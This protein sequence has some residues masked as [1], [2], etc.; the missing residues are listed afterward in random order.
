MGQSMRLIL[1]EA[2]Y[3]A[4][5]FAYINRASNRAA[6]VGCHEPPRGVRMPRSFSRAVTVRTL[7][8][9][10]ERRSSTMARR[11]AARCAAFAFTAATAC[12]LPTC[13]PL[14]ARAPFG[15]PSLTPRA[16]AAARA[17]LVRS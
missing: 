10:W 6:D 7:V 3:P 11:L 12:L 2:H 14:S 13:L 5:Q 1:A 16:F 9:P 15:L 8:N 4:F 17:A